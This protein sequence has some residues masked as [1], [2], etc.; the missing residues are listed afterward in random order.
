[1]VHAMAEW[2]SK[3]VQEGDTEHIRLSRILDVAQDLVCENLCLRW[4]YSY[5]CL[6]KETQS[7][8]TPLPRG[9]DQYPPVLLTF[10]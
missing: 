1:M 9:K 10:L 7:R 5:R 6:T 2:Y 8:G 3:A 4:R